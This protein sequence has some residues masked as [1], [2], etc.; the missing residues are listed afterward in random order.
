MSNQMKDIDWSKA[1]DCAVAALV[2]TTDNAH[3]PSVEFVTGYHAYG[4]MIRATSAVDGRSLSAPSDCWFLVD[5]PVSHWTGDGLPPVGV[6]CEV[7]N[8]IEGVWDAVD[9]V[10]AHTEIKGVH[11]AVFKRD[12]RVFYSPDGT[13]RPIRTPEQIA[14]EEREKAIEALAVELAGHWSSEAVSLQRETAAYLHDIGY[15]R[16]EQ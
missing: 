9:E 11:V 15:R 2:A 3:Y 12:D 6:A 14:A 5:R 13:F 8:D 7:E 1:P 4:C 10:L 16:V